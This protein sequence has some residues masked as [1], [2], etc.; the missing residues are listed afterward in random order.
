MLSLALT[1][2]EKDDV[3]KSKTVF[4]SPTV[5]TQSPETELVLDGDDDAVSLLQEKEMDNLGGKFSTFIHPQSQSPPQL[6]PVL[7]AGIHGKVHV[8]YSV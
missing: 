8:C 5:A 7:M 6:V 4:R 2:S 1:D 3:L